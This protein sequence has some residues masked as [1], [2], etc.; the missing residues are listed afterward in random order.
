MNFFQKIKE[1]FYVLVSDD[2][3]WA[4]PIQVLNVRPLT[5]QEAIGSPERNDFPLLK[6][7]EVMMQANFRGSLGQAFT[8]MP[9]SFSG[10][11]SE[12]FQLPLINNFQRAVFIASLNAV[13]RHS[14]YI[15]HTIHCKDMEPAECAAHLR[16]YIQEQFGKP[17]IAFVGLQPAMVERLSAIFKIRVVDLD[18]EN[19]GRKKCGVLIEDASNTREIISWADIMIAT[20]TTAVNHTLPSLLDQIPVIFYGVTIRGIAYLMN[21]RHYCFCS[22]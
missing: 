8:D 5:P 9:G 21:Y 14:G 1:K 20:G 22:H 13:L 4:S 10:S 11:L 3:I 2:T 12:V 7:K 18:K 16:D 15:T 6:G 17:R 19:V